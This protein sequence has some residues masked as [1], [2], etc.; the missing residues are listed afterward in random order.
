MQKKRMAFC[1]GL[2]LSVGFAVYPYRSS[3]QA[4]GAKTLNSP[5]TFSKDVAAIFKKQ[6]VTCHMPNGMAPM[7]LTTHNDEALGKIHP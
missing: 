2:L 1:A 5:A 3:I 4:A 7:S 6:C